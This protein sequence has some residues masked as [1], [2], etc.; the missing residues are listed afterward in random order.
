M[1]RGVQEGGEDWIPPHVH[2]MTFEDSASR[3]RGHGAVGGGQDLSRWFA[4]MVMRGVRT[5][6]LSGVC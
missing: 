5:S 1:V 4:T 2:F 3:V 6:S